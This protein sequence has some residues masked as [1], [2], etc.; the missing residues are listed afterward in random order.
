MDLYQR[1]LEIE[2]RQTQIERYRAELGASIQTAAQDQFNM[3]SGTIASLVNG[4]SPA[5]SWPTTIQYPWNFS[6]LSVM[7][8]WDTSLRARASN[9]IPFT[10]TPTGQYLSTLNDYMDYINGR[11]FNLTRLTGGQE[12]QP[13]TTTDLWTYNVVNASGS[14]KSEYVY[15][16][17]TALTWNS[18]L[19]QFIAPA[20]LM[21]PAPPYNLDPRPYGIGIG[22]FGKRTRSENLN[23]RFVYIGFSVDTFSF[24]WKEN[25]FIG[26]GNIT[27]PS[28]I[29]L[30]DYDFASDTG[31]YRTTLNT[32]NV[33]YTWS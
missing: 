13:S 9:T 19:G 1:L 21:S 15:G 14:W 22:A 30:I 26:S 4:S 32:A 12:N 17:V 5:E 11:T 25:L 23:P 3:D 31:P 7:A 18:I 10:Q 27:V 20:G 8:T 28:A 6:T 33:T 29:N 16:V 24:N 2:R